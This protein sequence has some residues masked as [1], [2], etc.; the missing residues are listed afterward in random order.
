VFKLALKR[1]RQKK[2]IESLKIYYW[3]KNLLQDI[4]HITG[5]PFTEIILLAERL[6]KLPE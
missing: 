2:N 1:E 3:L 4:A 5:L 6:K